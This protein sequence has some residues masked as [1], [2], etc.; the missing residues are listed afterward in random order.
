MHKFICPY[1]TIENQCSVSEEAL[2][3]IQ[4]AHDKL[5]EYFELLEPSDQ[6]KTEKIAKPFCLVNQDSEDDVHAIL[7]GDESTKVINSLSKVCKLYSSFKQLNK[8]LSK[9]DALFLIEISN[10]FDRRKELNS[11]T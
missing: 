4:R 1:K 11:L 10:Y 5:I 3:L 9:D 7:Q 6:Q 8:E 2:S